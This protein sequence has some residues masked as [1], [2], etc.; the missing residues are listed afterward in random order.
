MRRTTS[1]WLVRF[2]YDGTAFHGWARQPGLR[3]VE[4][5]IRRG[6]LRSAAVQSGEALSIEV[7]SRTDRGV[8]ARANALAFRSPLPGATLLRT[9]N[10]IDPD[11]FFTAA[12]L[13]PEEFRVRRAV[14]RTYHYFEAIRS[15]NPA[16]RDEAARLVR[17]GGRCAILR[18]F[19]SRR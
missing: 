17:G 16:L 11:I 7:A 8:S 12:T 1:R 5:E 6:L 10:G 4:G 9:L 19:R 15:Q 3:T 14:R 18:S 2:G 13:V